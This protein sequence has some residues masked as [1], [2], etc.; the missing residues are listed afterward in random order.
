MASTLPDMNE[1]VALLHSGQ[2]LELE[3]KARQAI[4]RYPWMG[5]IWKALGVS[6]RMQGKDAL[7][8]LHKAAQLLPEDAEAHVNLGNALLDRAQAAGAVASYRRA[9]ELA[10][11]FAEAHCNLGNALRALGHLDEAVESYRRAL[12]IKSD[13]AIAHSNLGN[14]L[15]A[16]GRLDEAVACYRRALDIDPSSAAAS[17]NL[18]NALMDLGRHE[19][20]LASYRRAVEIMPAFA[21]AH[22]NSGNALRKLGRLEDA[23]AGYRQALSLNPEF[24]PALSNLSDALRDLGRIAE[25]ADSSSRALAIAPESPGAHNTLGNALLD[26]GRLPEAEA[27]YRRAL[28]LDP[29]LAQAHLNLGMVLRLR[30]HPA[31]AAASCHAALEVNGDTAAAFVLLAELQADGGQFDAAEDSFQR[32]VAIDADLVEAWAAMVHLRKM[33]PAD[34]PWLLR[35]QTLAQRRL[36]PRQEVYLRY[37]MGKYFDDVQDFDG[38]FA[39]YRRANE[40]TKLYAPPHD[41]QGMTR[42]I[43]RMIEVYDGSWAARASA[44][45][46][47]ARCVFIIGMPRSGTTLVEQILA[48][49]PAVHGAGE[50]TFW[51]D[52]SAWIEALASG[53]R[54]RSAEV[55]RLGGDYLRLLTALSHDALRVVDKMPANF[56]SLGL[57]HEALP[58]ARFIHMQRSPL[59][60]C[61]SVYFQHFKSGHSYANDLE[62]IAHYYSQYSRLMA[63]WRATLPADVLL[64]VPYAGLVEDQE[65]WSRRMLAFIDLPWDARCLDFH[66]TDRNVITASKWQVRQK[67]TRR[68]VA[69][70]RNYERFLGPLAELG[71]S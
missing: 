47:S 48:S 16:L 19:D 7:E 45:D 56:L 36:P 10:P 39:S 26:L 41:R 11:G 14:A 12:S 60:T 20:A 42:K 28:A 70:W 67:I 50:L 27:C 68:A 43:D 2:F 40:L 55:S 15:R 64:E 53:D 32:A 17:N 18:G 63:H 29:G 61:L 25:A 58:G 13:L 1:I 3:N 6:L 9:L 51:G 34:A 46:V 52:A 59:D 38:A 37:A 31:A 8:A 62:E 66:R 69:R 23:V 24:A 21:E 44:D 57:I 65:A 33:T 30:G 4:A 71:D 49:H 54:R 22:S 5:L 35:A